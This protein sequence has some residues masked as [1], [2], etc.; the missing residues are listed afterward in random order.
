MQW[1]VYDVC[2]ALFVDFVS[3]VFPPANVNAILQFSEDMQVISRQM[4]LC[5]ATT[6]GVARG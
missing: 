6:I 2:V 1:F 3:V 5:S 4:L